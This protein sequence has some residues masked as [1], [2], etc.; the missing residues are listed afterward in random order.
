MASLVPDMRME[1]AEVLGHSASVVLTQLIVKGTSTDGVVM[2][3]PLFVIDVH[4]GEHVTHM[5]TFD[6]DQRDLALAR[7]QELNG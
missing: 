2:E 4:D 3:L 1:L 5:E 6:I 7:F